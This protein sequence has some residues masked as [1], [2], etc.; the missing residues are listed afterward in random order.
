MSY[1]LIM[2]VMLGNVEYQRY[3]AYFQDSKS[4]GEMKATVL[5][6][7]SIYFPLAEPYKLVAECIQVK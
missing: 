3:T 4:C 5:S 7:D 6:P 2:I 1:L